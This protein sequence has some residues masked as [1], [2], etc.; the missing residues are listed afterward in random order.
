MILA[1]IVGTVVGPEA[2]ATT[3]RLEPRSASS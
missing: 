1:K 3:I 2:H